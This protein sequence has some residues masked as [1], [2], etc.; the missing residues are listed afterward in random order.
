MISKALFH[1]SCVANSFSRDSVSNK[2]DLHMQQ[3][4]KNVKNEILDLNVFFRYLT[5]FCLDFRQ[6]KDECIQRKKEKKRK[7]RKKVRKK[8]RKKE[9]KKDSE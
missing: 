7:E 4:K 2:F 8:E 6:L 9:R 3:G 1:L 5:T